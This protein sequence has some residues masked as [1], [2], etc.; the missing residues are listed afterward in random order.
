MYECM[1]VFFFLFSFFSFLS[2]FI[3]PNH[4]LLFLGEKGEVKKICLGEIANGVEDGDWG[5]GIGDWGYEFMNL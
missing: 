2:W 5:L 3:M 4:T 1:Y